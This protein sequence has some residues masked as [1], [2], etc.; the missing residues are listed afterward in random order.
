MLV[1][2]RRLRAAA[3]RSRAARPHGP[4][5]RRRRRA[6]HEGRRRSPRSRS[7]LDPERRSCRTAAIPSAA[8]RDLDARAGGRPTSGLAVLGSVSE[9][10]RYWHA[11]DALAT[12]PLGPVAEFTG[13]PLSGPAPLTVDFTDLSSGGPTHWSWDF[14]DGQSSTEHEPQHVYAQPGTF[15]VTLRSA[16]GAGEDARTRTAYVVVGAPSPVKPFTP[17]A[18][19]RLGRQPDL[20]CRDL[21]RAAREEPGGEHL[22]ELPALRPRSVSAAGDLGQ[23]APLLHGREQRRRAASTGPQQHLD[24]DRP[25]TWNNR[26]ALPRLVPWSGLAAE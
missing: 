23:A 15:S 11:F 8:L 26:P 16:N 25:S 20:H 7:R 14:G 5:R 21:E 9:T 13:S 6:V 12:R 10:T 18:D 17:V 22:P 19:A 3:P 24:R 2:D 1:V 4:E